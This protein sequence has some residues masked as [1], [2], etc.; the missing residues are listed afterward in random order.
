MN[1]KYKYILEPNEIEYES[2]NININNYNT[3]EYINCKNNRLKKL[4]ILPK[5]L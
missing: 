1:I 4:F 2:N 3:I 5:N